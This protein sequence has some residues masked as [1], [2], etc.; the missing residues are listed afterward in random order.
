MARVIVFFRQGVLTFATKGL[1]HRISLSGRPS[2]TIPVGMGGSHK[3]CH[4]G[5]TCACFADPRCG[6]GLVHDLDHACLQSWAQPRSAAC[7][8]LFQGVKD[9]AGGC[10]R[11]GSG[12][13]VAKIES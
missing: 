2:I 3:G 1:R 11:P 13:K 9:A 5:P 7:L 4:A 6:I 8:G 10:Q 12:S